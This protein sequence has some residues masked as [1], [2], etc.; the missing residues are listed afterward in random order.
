MNYHLSMLLSVFLL[1]SVSVGAMNKEDFSSDVDGIVNAKVEKNNNDEKKDK[2][3]INYQNLTFKQKII[4]SSMTIIAIGLVF[5]PIKC[6]SSSPF[7][8]PEVCGYESCLNQPS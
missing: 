5:L 7:F 4:S 8:S 3:I 6:F 2:K 1:F